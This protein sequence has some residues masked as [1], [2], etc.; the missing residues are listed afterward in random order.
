MDNLSRRD[1][2]RVTGTGLLVAATGGSLFTM[3]GCGN[4]MTD[5]INWGPVGQ[6]SFDSIMLLLQNAGLE[7]PAMLLIVPVINKG[8]TDLIADAKLYESIQPP[9]AGA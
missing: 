5:I 1:F 7:S 3:T 4:V 2:G 6:A 9:P 8:F